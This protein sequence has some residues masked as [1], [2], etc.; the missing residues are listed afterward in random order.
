MAT[1]KKKTT[2]RKPAAK[3]N[4]RKPQKNWAKYI[5]S[6]LLLVM[7]IGS[8]AAAFFV[9]FFSV[10]KAH[11]ATGKTVE[12]RLEPAK[13]AIIIDDM[14]Y[15]KKLGMAFI[16]LPYDLTFSFLPS[17]PF[18]EYLQKAG[19]IAGKTIMVHVPLE[20]ND[21]SLNLEP[22]T[23]LREQDPEKQKQLFQ[24]IVAAVPLAT[25]M[26]NHMGS[27]YTADP[28]AMRNLLSLAKKHDFFFVDSV[29]TGD[30]VGPKMASELGMPFVKRDVF[31][32]NVTDQDTICGQL[33]KLVAVAG[34]SGSA[35][36][37]GHPHPETL[38]ALQT[39][40]KEYLG[41]THLVPV[42]E[43]VKK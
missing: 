11:A 28:D 24:D 16:N 5:I 15:S 35:V 26:N 2:S 9:V 33:K 19:Y 31:L 22:D 29:T 37:I 12:G 6:L 27:R 4:K 20:P 14:G 1:R 36:G 30:S 3:R 41:N 25:G 23:L 43:L 39:C 32:D 38:G 42:E 18:S 17:A 34:K 13:V 10:P 8:I 40:L 21:R 7:F